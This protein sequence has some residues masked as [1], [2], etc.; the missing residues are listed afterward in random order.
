[1]SDLIGILYHP[2]L[3]EALTLSEA[4]SDMLQRKGYETWTASAWQ[5]PSATEL[6]T[7]TRALVTVG[8]DGTILRAARSLVPT[9]IPII[10]IRYGRLGFLAE[11]VPE[12]ALEQ[13]P[14]L[15]EQ[16]E[17]PETRSLLRATCAPSVLD[18]QLSQQHH[19]LL[20]SEPQIN[21]LN[22]VVIARGAVGRPIT[23]HVAID[24]QPYTSYRADAV[25]LATATGS[26]GYALAAGG[27]VLYPTSQN[28]LLV[29]VSAHAAL[30]NALIL[31]P[32][33]VAE[34]TVRS[35][36][37]AFLS[38]DGQID[39]S[40]PDGATVTV[41]RSPYTAHFLRMAPQE[42]FYAQLLARL[43]FGDQVDP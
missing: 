40:L 34:L 33:T 30:A 14:V 6:L 16:K 29:P 31:E 10:G 2:R 25:I 22:D 35:D 43:H 36:H 39:V 21:A 27:P 7:Q 28:F 37:G 20:T 4:L 9:S 23:V 17:P 41:Q 15:L 3:S 18:A 5:E 8:G 1:M 11:V 13:V 42:Q 26:T 12:E 32:D 19:P 38:I 24:S